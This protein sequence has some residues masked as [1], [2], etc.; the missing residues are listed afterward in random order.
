MAVKGHPL[1]WHT[2][3]AP[4]LSDL[5]TDEIA[6]AQVARIQREVE[7]FRGL[8]DTWDVINEVV[9]MPCVRSVRQRHHASCA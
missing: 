9:I 1:C 6:A 3:T 2:E 4:W 5:T 8:I 7:D